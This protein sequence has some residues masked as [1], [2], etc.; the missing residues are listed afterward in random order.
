MSNQ[1]KSQTSSHKTH[2]NTW[3][4]VENEKISERQEDQLNQNLSI[5][6]ATQNEKN[7]QGELVFQGP[8]ENNINLSNDFDDEE[9]Q[10]R[11]LKEA[12]AGSKTVQKYN[13]IEEYL[14]HSLIDIADTAQMV[15][16]K[17]WDMVEDPNA[18]IRALTKIAE[19]AGYNKKINIVK[20]QNPYAPMSKNALLYKND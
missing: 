20:I 15:N 13:S 3:K 4:Q 9:A 12:L 5:V 1:S 14:M 18:K 6:Q 8:K 10:I 19:M 2:G 17:T 11:K 16:S 7:L